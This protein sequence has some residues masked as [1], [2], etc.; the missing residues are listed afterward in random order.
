MT[1]LSN[2]RVKSEC[3]ARRRRP[4]KGIEPKPQPDGNA[5]VA[6]GL[7]S[8]RGAGS[9]SLRLLSRGCQFLFQS[10]YLISSAPPLSKHETLS[11]FPILLRR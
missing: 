5:S 3:H 9:P 6:A 2:G 7:N 1:L 11:D 10:I 8:R 4:P